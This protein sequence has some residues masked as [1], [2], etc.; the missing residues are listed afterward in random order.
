MDE[1]EVKDV[2]ETE[3]ETSEPNSV[4]ES[5]IENDSLVIVLKSEL[6]KIALNKNFTI[7]KKPIQNRHVDNLVDTIITRT[8]E[9]TKFTSY[10]ATN[11][12][13]IYKAKI[14]NSEFALNDFIK[15]GTKKYVVEKSLAKE[16]QNGILK[17]GNLEQTS[18]FNLIFKF[19][20]LKLIEY[21]GYVD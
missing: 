15:V 17:I 5:Y 2:V 8:F 9:N 19:G 11:E 18:V 4:A 21:D 12:E 20:I 6:E 3:K 14:E 1:S 16:I 7:E 13:W 10:K